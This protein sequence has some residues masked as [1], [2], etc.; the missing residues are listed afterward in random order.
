MSTVGPLLLA[1]QQKVECSSNRP[2]FELAKKFRAHDAGR[3]G[4]VDS[5][6]LFKVLLSFRVNVDNSGIDDL[7]HVYNVTGDGFQYTKF[8]GDLEKDPRD[9]KNLYKNNSAQANIS[10]VRRNNGEISMP[11]ASRQNFG[12]TQG[13][14]LGG[15]SSRTGPPPQ[16]IKQ[17]IQ[18]V[19]EWRE[20]QRSISVSREDAGDYG[21]EMYDEPMH[22]HHDHRDE[23]RTGRY[24][25][26]G[27]DG[28][29]Y[30]YNEASYGASSARRE[31]P[32]RSRGKQTGHTEHS[33]SKNRTAK[34]GGGGGGKKAAARRTTGPN[35][36]RPGP[37]VGI[38]QASVGGSGMAAIR[39]LRAKE[40][41]RLVQN[42]NGQRKA[43]RSRPSSRPV[44]SSGLPIS[45]PGSQVTADDVAD[46]RV[47]QTRFDK[48]GTLAV[49]ATALSGFSGPTLVTTKATDDGSGGKRKTS[50]HAG[51]RIFSN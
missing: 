10:R 45:A 35:K 2:W 20:R 47:K 27:R 50:S 23:Q 32:P 7:M 42:K 4:H 1:I 29:D 19:N 15:D 39:Q 49:N 40:G 36:G 24:D 26:E 5:Q 43:T 22:R 18:K 48:T 9:L 13:T 51:T 12:A 16:E 34:V 37:G 31:E 14:A 28:G 3:R 6:A 41:P 8:V 46:G 11:G 21:E 33:S 30:D 25:D 17:S 38:P 44:S